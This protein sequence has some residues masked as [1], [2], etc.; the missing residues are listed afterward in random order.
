MKNPA[1]IIGVGEMGGVFARGLLR[2]GF[3][4]TDVQQLAQH[5]GDPELVLVAVAEGDLGE[6]PAQLA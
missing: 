3:R 2:S 1:V 5:I 4:A 6:N